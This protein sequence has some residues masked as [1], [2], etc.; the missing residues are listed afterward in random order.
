MLLGLPSTLIQYDLKTLL[1]WVKTK[2]RTY[3]V[4]V[5]GQKRNKMKTMTE[6]IAGPCVGSMGVDLKLSHNVQFYRF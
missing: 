6:N 4:G 1:K 2:T 3:R 5:D